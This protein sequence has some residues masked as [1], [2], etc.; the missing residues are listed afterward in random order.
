MGILTVTQF[1]HVSGIVQKEAVS[2]E[3]EP[4]NDISHAT[5]IDPGDETSGIFS[6]LS[7]KDFYR[8]A[9]KRP[10][11]VKLAFMNV[12]PYTRID[13]YSPDKTLISESSIFESFVVRAS[14]LQL[15]KIGTYYIVLSSLS[16]AKAQ[17]P[18]SISINLSEL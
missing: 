7:D 5:P 2:H 17:T 18:Y 4:N 6:T 9:I 8:F 13:L 1:S 11:D 14:E 12:P 16:N 10:S 3:V 15:H